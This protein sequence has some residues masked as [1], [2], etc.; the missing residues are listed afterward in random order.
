MAANCRPRRVS[1]F[2]RGSQRR[3]TETASKDP[4]GGLDL[5]AIPLTCDKG[6]EH[7][8]SFCRSFVFLK[9]LPSF[10]DVDP[11]RL[12]YLCAISKPG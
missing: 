9:A 2:G 10:P 1:G 6:A 12:N 4:S 5:D 11:V 7:E 8:T 3:P